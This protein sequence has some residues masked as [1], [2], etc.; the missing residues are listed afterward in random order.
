M[1]ISVRGQQKRFVDSY[2]GERVTPLHA[3]WV[4]I[5][6]SNFFLLQFT[7]SYC[8]L[9][10]SIGSF[11]W[12]LVRTAGIMLLNSIV[13]NNI[14][15]WE[16]LHSGMITYNQK[17]KTW[18]SIVVRGKMTYCFLVGRRAYP[19]PS[20]WRCP[21]FLEMFSASYQ[22]PAAPFPSPLAKRPW[23]HTCGTSHIST[24]QI[25][26]PSQETASLWFPSFSWFYSLCML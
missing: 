7:K 6:P 24:T 22:M 12:P 11:Q 25:M 4:V 14:S 13:K 2:V 1:R 17:M 23:R 18:P 16:N 26:I 15:H 10:L 3:R 19:W 21:L 20:P 5:K 9:N 8:M